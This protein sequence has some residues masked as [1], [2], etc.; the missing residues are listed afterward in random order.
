MHTAPALGFAH[1][2]VD[3][4]HMHGCLVHMHACLVHMRFEARHHV[5][6]THTREIVP[7]TRNAG[8]AQAAYHSMSFHT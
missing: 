4:G 5:S 2:A 8:A 7:E 3:R 1:T 6:P